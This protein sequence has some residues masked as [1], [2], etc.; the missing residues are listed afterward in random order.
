MNPQAMIDYR[1]GPH[2]VRAWRDRPKMQPRRRDQIEIPCIRKKRE[3]FVAWLRQ[4]ELRLE[5]P[6]MHGAKPIPQNLFLFRQR[7]KAMITIPTKFIMD[8]SPP[9]PPYPPFPPYPPY[10][11]VIICC[12]HG[13]AIYAPQPQQAGVSAPPAGVSQPPATGGT[14]AGGGKQSGIQL[15]NPLDVVLGPAAGLAG[16]VANFA[17]DAA[18]VVGQVAGGIQDFLDSIF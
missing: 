10:P 7:A 5:I 8:S 11:P 13:G 9:Y 1:V 15:P 4:P 14:P 3:H 2:F 18:G 12:C 17:Q 16:G 6:H